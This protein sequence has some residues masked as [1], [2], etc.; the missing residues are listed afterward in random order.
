M[1]IEKSKIE[2]PIDDTKEN[3]KSFLDDGPSQILFS[4]KFGTGKTYFLDKFFNKEDKDYNIFHLFPVNYQ[5]QDANGDIIDLIKYDILIELLKKDENIF[6]KNNSEDISMVQYIK[7]EFDTNTFL[8]SAIST[9][10]D[11]IPKI[12]KVLGKPLK[13]LSQFHSNFQK[14][15]EGE[16]GIVNEYIEKIRK[17]NSSNETDIL[18]EIIKRKIEGL[19]KKKILEGLDKKKI[20]ILDD[21]D[22]VDPK[23]IFRLLNIFSSFFDQNGGNKFGF[24]KIII[25]ADYNNLKSI[26]HHQYGNDTDFL[27]YIDKFFTTK[28]YHFDNKKSILNTID[29][30]LSTIKSSDKNLENSLREDGDLQFILKYFF[31][32]TTSNNIINLRELLKSTKYQLNNLKE[33]T[34]FAGLFGD[35]RKIENIFDISIRILLEIFLDKENLIKVINK[36][37]VSDNIDKDICIPFD[38]YIGIMLKV[39][40]INVKEGEKVSIKSNYEVEGIPT[41]FTYL[42]VIS[43]SEEKL[44]LE[45]LI[46]YINSGKYNRTYQEY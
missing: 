31:T 41:E 19:D 36:I 37:L 5:I 16:K 40:N 10:V 15:K 23:Y 44:F 6:D 3:F 42:K 26:F 32:Q 43:G 45:L 22:R 46:D 20:L 9:L 1:T 33:E 8:R 25:V 13:D 14:F 18:S 12:G 29:I 24:D 38:I 34:F 7:K 30:I 28:P 17:S 35:E 11:P 27:G 2:I 39:L 4:G 21:L